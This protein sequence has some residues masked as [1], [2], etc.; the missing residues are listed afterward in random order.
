MEEIE[1]KRDL[2]T[3]K[4]VSEGVYLDVVG[5]DLEAIK[6]ELNTKFNNASSF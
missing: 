2:V 5:N 1:L 6:D 4:G 3:F